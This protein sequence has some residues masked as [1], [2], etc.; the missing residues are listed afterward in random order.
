MIQIN[1][2][3]S[4]SF[5][6]EISSEAREKLEIWHK[7]FLE[8]NSHTNLM[9]KNDTKVVFEKHV[10]DSLAIKLFEGFKPDI[11]LLDVGCGGGFPSLILSICFPEITFFAVD[12]TLKKIN[13]LNLAKHELEL[14][15]LNPI[16]DRIENIKPLGVDIITNRAVGKI[17]DIWSLS[18][19]HL[20]SG[21]YFV[22]YKAKTAKEEA[23]A[24]EEKFAKLKNPLFIPYRL[25]LDE[26]FTRELV[27]FKN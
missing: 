24:A 2:L 20:K 6:F 13:F 3:I 23:Y 18:C 16:S 1:D 5:G 15:N 25:P 22:S 27:I 8:Y 7:I 12:S 26:N 21:G 10:T 4:K 14:H 19:A 17:S 9:S 11:S